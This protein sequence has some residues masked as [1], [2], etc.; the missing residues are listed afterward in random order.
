MFDWVGLI[1]ALLVV[2]GCLWGSWVQLTK[3][4]NYGVKK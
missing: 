2:L 3:V 1:V 4:R